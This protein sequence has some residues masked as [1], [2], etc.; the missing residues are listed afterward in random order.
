M[1]INTNTKFNSNY[2]LFGIIITFILILLLELGK[3]PVPLIGQSNSEQNYIQLSKGDEIRSIS[4]GSWVAVIQKDNFQPIIGI[5]RGNVEKNLLIE[6]PKN[7]GEELIPYSKIDILYHGEMNRYG[8]YIRKG[9][10]YGALTTIFFGSGWAVQMVADDAL[11]YAP[12]AYMC[13]GAVFIPSGALL[14]Y[15]KALKENNEVTEYILSDD[16]GW[17]IE[18]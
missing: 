6:I 14:G 18:L 16:T 3:F 12:F 7:N 1:Q 10:G 5:L 8:H 2:Y 13:G 4:T 9:I 15:I 17:S 11:M